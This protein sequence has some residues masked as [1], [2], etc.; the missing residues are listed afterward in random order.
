MKGS[1]G[2]SSNACASH[3]GEVI[4]DDGGITVLQNGVV[5]ELDPACPDVPVE[6]IVNKLMPFPLTFPGCCQADSTCG[7][8]TPCVS[9]DLKGIVP[10]EGCLPYTRLSTFVVRVSSP[11]SPV[12]HCAYRRIPDAGISGF[13]AAEP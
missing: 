6:V 12:P 8:R 10:P 4:L 2:S 1:G 13:E 9:D 11:P 5:I 7:A 3:E